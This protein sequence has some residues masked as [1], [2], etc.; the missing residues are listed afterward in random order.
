MRFNMSFEILCE[1]FDHSVCETREPSLTILGLIWFPCNIIEQFEYIKT[2]L[3]YYYSTRPHLHSRQLHSSSRHEVW[4]CPDHLHHHLHHP[5][6]HWSHLQHHLSLPAGQGE[7]TKKNQ[8]QNEFIVDSSC[9]CRSC[10]KIWIFGRKIFN[11][12]F[13]S[14]SYCFK[15]PLKWL[16]PTLFLGQLM[17]SLVESWFL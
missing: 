5:L 16:G 14:R 3:K 7:S 2:I 6:C 4:W 11:A 12:L 13:I 10:G 8:K 9:H 15:F 17:T 1:M